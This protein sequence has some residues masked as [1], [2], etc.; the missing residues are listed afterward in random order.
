MLQATEIC[1]TEMLV[2][3]EMKEAGG[4]ELLPF[5]LICAIE[6]LGVVEFR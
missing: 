4:E 6:G 1:K 5:C 3:D 2:E